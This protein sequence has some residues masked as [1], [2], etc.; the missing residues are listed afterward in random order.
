MYDYYKP[1][2]LNTI[3]APIS[4]A[5]RQLEIDH[6]CQPIYDSPFKRNKDVY[7]DLR[8]QF[9]NIPSFKWWAVKYNVLEAKDLLCRDK[10]INWQNKMMQ[11]LL[12]H[13]KVSNETFDQMWD[14]FIADYIYQNADMSNAEKSKDEVYQELWGLFS[15][16][17]ENIYKR[18]YNPEYK[19]GT[20]GTRIKNKMVNTT[21]ADLFE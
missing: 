9:A 16:T 4:A 14:N 8:D 20:V 17:V 18:K 19:L 12:T 21:A 3:P 13:S 6:K 1:L 10:W 7:W 2:D 5:V 15:K 11:Q